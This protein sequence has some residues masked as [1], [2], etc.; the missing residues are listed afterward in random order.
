ML[1]KQ[2]L[3]IGLGGGIGS[4]MRFL[5]SKIPFEQD[6]FPW[7]TFVVNI[8]GCFLI[9]LLIGLSVL[10]LYW[11]RDM[12]L[13]LVTGFCGGFTTF[14]TFSTENVSL[15]YSGNY[16]LLGAYILLSVIVGFAAV[17]LGLALSK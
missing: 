13:F 17:L 10:H 16:F 8:V 6:S 15:Y 14:S 5:V 3:L 4:M 7:A 2:L 1:V 9:G 12:R 11:G